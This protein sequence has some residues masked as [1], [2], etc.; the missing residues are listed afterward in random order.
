MTCETVTGLGDW[1]DKLLLIDGPYIRNGFIQV[2]GKPG[3][4]VDVNPDVAKAHLA[5][6]ETW[7]G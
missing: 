4:G 2:N 3:I 1:M 6:G 7:W 5:P